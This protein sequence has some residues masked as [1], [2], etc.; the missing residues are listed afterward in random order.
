MVH[1]YF[2]DCHIF[3]VNVNILNRLF[4]CTFLIEI[5]AIVHQIICVYVISVFVPIVLAVYY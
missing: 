5:T 1:I 2:R 3:I 4:D